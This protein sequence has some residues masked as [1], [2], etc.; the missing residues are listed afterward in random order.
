M[1]LPRQERGT[2]EHRSF[3]RF[4]VSQCGVVV[5]TEGARVVHVRGD[6]EHPLSG[7][8]TCSKGRSLPQFHHDPRRL[9]TPAL[10]RAGTSRSDVGWEELIE[11]LGARVRSIIEESGPHA[12]G[13]F[14]GT[15]ASLDSA[16]AALAGGFGEAIGT[17]SVYSP[18]TIDGPAKPL[19]GALVGGHPGLFAAGIDYERTTMTLLVGTN[20]LVSHGHSTAAPGP[21]PR[22]RH[23]LDRG[24]VWVVDPRRTETARMATRHLAP[25]PGTDHIWLAAVIRELLR[26]VDVDAL[27]ARAVGV[28][29]LEEAVAPFTLDVAARRSGLDQSQLEE[30]VEALQRHGRFAG[31][32]GT[33]VTMSQAGTVAQWLMLVLAVITDS[34][35]APGGIWFNP[36]FVRSLDHKPW[37]R[38]E[39]RPGRGPDSH[40]EL[41]FQFAQMPSAAIVDEIEHG[42]LRALIVAGGN[43]TTCLPDST[44]TRAAL[45]SIEIL[46]V[47]DVVAS[48]MT[49]LATHLVPCTGQLERPDITY[50]AEQYLPEVA[51]QYTPAVIPAGA[52]R[53]PMWWFFAR[54]GEEL[55]EPLLPPGLSPDSCTAD[56]ILA[57]FCSGPRADFDTIRS[58]ARATVA[59]RAVFGWV[60][61]GVAARGGWRLAPAQLVAALL[62]L[63]DPGD[64]PLL[65]PRRQMNHLNAQLVTTPERKARSD[66][67]DVLLNP[68]DAARLGI[69]DGQAVRVVS[70]NGELTGQAKVDD[71]IRCGAVSIPH[72]YE[73]V[74]VN[75]L[76][77][78]SHDL[79]P[80][81]GMP[82]YSGVP[83]EVM[84][85]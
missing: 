17:R 65:V 4:C 28:E 44:R 82:L 23:L 11:D 42:H 76:T 20:P 39:H 35:D 18:L 21:R 41:P 61:E 71:D 75:N 70:A 57:T 78:A 83:V 36:G 13:L 52:M 27:R 3:C 54:L 74:A 26:S 80:L 59:E 9:D 8:Y 6:R 45:E 34:A 73:Q 62:A 29:G 51:V 40:P 14:I 1:S 25:R 49:E 47:A 64:G 33:G 37:R 15:G 7:G 16:G 60:R 50:G 43:L 30:L 67:P 79:D 5:T 24:E 55:A 58:A 77:S 19:V 84:P 68:G 31:L 53:K 10:G 63:E 66:D 81:T 38:G 46:A 22:L 12:I 85:G 56:D 48:D 69:A 2:T 72:G 32:T